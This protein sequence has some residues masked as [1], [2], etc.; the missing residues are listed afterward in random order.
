MPAG[1]YSHFVR[2]R[3]TDYRFGKMDKRPDIGLGLGGKS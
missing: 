3:R 1:G 2:V